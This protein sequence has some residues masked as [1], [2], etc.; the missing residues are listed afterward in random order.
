MFRGFSVRMAMA[1]GLVHKTT[2]NSNNSRMEY[3]GNFVGVL[4]ALSDV[5]AGG[6]IIMD[7][8]TFSSINSTLTELL[9]RVPKHPDYAALRAPF[10]VSQGWLNGITEVDH[11]PSEQGTSR[12]SGERQA[13]KKWWQRLKREGDKDDAGAGSLIVMDMGMHVFHDLP[14]PKQLFQILVPG[15]EERARMLPKLSTAEQ[16]SPG[17]L[18][19]PAAASAPLSPSAKLEA[20]LPSVTIVFC[21]LDG[22]K[23]MKALDGIAVSRILVLY[24]DTLRRVLRQ[25]GG[26]ECQESEGTFMLVFERPLKAVQFCLLV[27]ELMVEVYWGEDVTSMAP[28]KTQVGPNGQLVFLGPR[29]KMGLY[30]GVPDRITPHVTAGKADYFGT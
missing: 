26:Y 28:C 29:V 7:S 22:L 10:G 6:Q 20:G 16:L 5:P 24:R 25:T 27:Q 30:Q 1:T 15:L 23:I 11:L 8:Q 9:Q 17:Y 14:E 3:E 13:P 2:I 21:S 18:D 12:R 4:Q 19:A